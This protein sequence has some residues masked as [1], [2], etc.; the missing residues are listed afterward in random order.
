M[1]FDA[2]LI[3]RFRRSTYLTLA[4]ACAALG[5][6]ELTFLPETAVFMVIV[7]VLLT[8]AYRAEGRWTLGPRAA[9]AIGAVIGVVSIGWVIYQFFRPWGGTLLDQLPWPTSLLP[10]LGPMLMILIPA[11]LF[12]PK[13]AGDFWGLQG[14]GLMAVALG[15]ALAG[16]LPFGVLMACYLASLVWNL[17]LFYLVRE[18]ERP[19][20]ALGRTR[21]VNAARHG[22]RWAVGVLGFALALFLLT[23]R[24]GDARWELLL[25]GRLQV[26]LEDR[27]AIDLNRSGTVKSNRDL[28]Y[29]VVARTA[30]GRPK[31]DLDPAQRWSN[32]RFN[33]YENGRWEVRQVF[34]RDQ[35]GRINVE[36]VM[37]PTQREIDEILAAY[38]NRFTLV[39]Y[40]QKNA[41]DNLLAE[42]VWRGRLGTSVERT[43]SVSS[44]GR[45]GRQRNWVPRSEGDFSPPASVMVAGHRD[46]YRQ[47]IVPPDE[48]G[49]TQARGDD[50]FYRQ[51]MCDC[52]S[53]P[54]LRKYTTL[55]V[56]RMIDDG[57]LPE[58]VWHPND[59]PPDSNS[60]PPPHAERVARALESYLATSGR[61]RYSLELPRSDERLD[62]VED[63][64]TNTRIGHCNRFAS[65]LTL[66]LRS[67]GIPARIVLGFQGHESDTDGI[68][69][70]RQC[71]AHSW[72]EAMI[73]RI[74][75]GEGAWKWLTLDP[76]PTGEEFQATD[77][78]LGYWWEN[79]RFSIGAWFRNFILEYD[80]DQQLRAASAVGSMTWPQIRGL[81]L[82]VGVI[83]AAIG[84]IVSAVWLRRRR[85]RA[86]N[87]LSV[88]PFYRRW[89]SVIARRLGLTPM[90]GQ[91]PAEFARSTAERL[92]ADWRDVP[93][94]VAAAYY[95][96]RF[97]GRRLEDRELHRL[98]DR[99]AQLDR[100]LAVPAP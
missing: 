24:S 60:V 96:V 85:Q 56:R 64:L 91:T 73:R 65:A 62:P 99:I 57:R 86:A 6:A 10:Y 34:R 48:P 83:L 16:D 29:E 39:F 52:H 63:F 94:E 97:G 12:R 36:P 14:I 42:P 84:V 46:P 9:N 1:T 79:T 2:P 49:I 23:P 53:V 27:P 54:T 13:H 19:G 69:E 47:T 4:I 11:K 100:A 74:D 44:Q 93:G 70:I 40:P 43:P 88:A 25:H 72:V 82:F 5:Y 30:D 81:M 77:H 68:Y 59:D 26:G 90:H 95:R 41:P 8:V 22:G 35:P 78:S 80:A 37:P 38:P 17:T 67:Q 21:P 28:V 18:G 61:F 58:D 3:V 71:H 87:G 32:Q 31:T 15:C 76:T 89:L 66:M 98:N 33:Y 92:S 51:A 45:D 55:L 20:V 50:D 75:N 7:A